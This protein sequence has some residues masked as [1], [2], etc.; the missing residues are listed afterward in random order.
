MGTTVN[1]QIFLAYISTYI[2][3]SYIF[4]RLLGNISSQV[5]WIPFY[6]TAS[7]ECPSRGN[8]WER[9]FER[10]YMGVFQGCVVIVNK[11]KLENC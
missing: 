3:Q 9:R 7:H 10:S 4:E 1:F 8:K 11:K 2:V 5:L 6:K